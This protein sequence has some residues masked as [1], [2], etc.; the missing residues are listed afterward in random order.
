[1][2]KILYV[3]LCGAL[4]L[5]GC[6]NR[7]EP[8]DS[9]STGK[10]K[11]I[12][13]S[14]VLEKN[15]RA[16]A[17]TSANI[18]NF[19]VAG[20]V[21][22][23]PTPAYIQN[24]GTGAHWAYVDKDASSGS[25][26]YSP[27]AEWPAGEVTFLAYS[28]QGANTHFSSP[29]LI[30]TNSDE[31]EMSTLTYSV[32]EIMS[33]QKD[34]LVSAIKQTFA[35]GAGTVT[36]NFK[37]ALSRLQFKARYVTGSASAITVTDI[38]LFNLKKT[39]TLDLR[40]ALPSGS[41]AWTNLNDELDSLSVV[42]HPNFKAVIPKGTDYSPV[43]VADSAVMAMPQPTT[44]GS[45]KYGVN[46]QPGGDT[47]AAKSGSAFYVAVTWAMGAGVTRTSLCA[48]PDPSDLSKGIEFKPG[49]QYT[50][51]FTLDSDANLITVGD[52]TVE[53]LTDVDGGVVTPPAA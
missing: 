35:P 44:L 7:Y 10:G 48:V 38:S 27:M 22:G 51:I 39:G 24:L 12:G 31:T 11:A 49:K 14:A 8:A 23:A 33:G 26:T 20:F 37:H 30:D 18:N 45:S 40:T 52:V 17:T 13:F 42:P 9:A 43:L 41:L 36:L 1:M 46:T 28:P 2:N 3:S 47:D 29:S 4:L 25:W 32:S 53:D 50:L 5:G 6:Q 21:A 15:S 19:A 34:F 16:E